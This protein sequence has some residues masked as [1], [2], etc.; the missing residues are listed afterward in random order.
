MKA[1]TKIERWVQELGRK[2]PPV[3]EAK[4][5]WAF[6]LFPKNG[7]YLKK[8]EVWCQCCG[9]VDRV[10]IPELAV[11]LAV[12]AHTCPHCG[13]TL[14]LKHHQRG[15]DT[16]EKRMVS[17]I[18]RFGGW[19]V[20]RTF[21]ADR[22]NCKGEPTFYEMKEIYRNWVHDD[23]R[24]VVESRPYTRSPFHLT[25]Q[26]WKPMQIAKHNRRCS[27]YY[28]MEDMFDPS[29][30]WFYPRMYVTPKLIR[31]G[32]RNCFPAMSLPAVSAMR[33]LLSN[34]VAETVVKQG[35][36]D[37]F[38]HMLRRG[39]YQLP[40]RHAL[41][42]CHR[43]GYV[44]EDAQMWFDYMEL[45]SYFNLDTHSPHYVCPADLKAEHD[46]LVR[47]KEREE[48]RRCEAD[49]VKQMRLD[50]QRY[51][52]DKAA[53]IGLAFTG[54]DGLAAHVLGSVEEFYREGEAMRHCVYS[55]GYYR[56]ADC[57]ILSATVGGKRMETVEVSLRTFRIVQSRAVCNGVSEWHNRI[58]ELVN[59]NM[60]LIKERMNV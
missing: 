15:M 17:F 4:R 31:N 41:N 57:L 59:R 45:L 27:G 47:R 28:E 32:W 25:W 34:P 26:T 30:N 58:I 53:F 19:N 24:E 43:N 44:I 48:A 33:Q 9:H 22:T 3:S 29:G 55:N 36:L 10:L 18:Q 7:L 35:Q 42:I 16:A 13:T 1:R 8:G 54:E 39:D 21:L 2:L 40:F 51:A 52:R 46:R 23:G 37:M 49:R 56:R 20:I 11:S 50:Q 14:T 60:K 5:K 12:G 38:R 6:G